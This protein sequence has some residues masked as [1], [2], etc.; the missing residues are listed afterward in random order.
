M[1]A[2]AP[3][4]GLVKTRLCPPLSDEQAA[5][6]SAAFALDTWRAVA[7]VSGVDPLLVYA[8][9][10]EAFPLALR[11]VVGFEQAGE[12]LGAR[13][14]NAARIGLDRA[15]RAIVIGSDAPALP[16]E[17]LRLASA[18]LQ[19]SDAVLGPALD[20]GYYLIGLRRCEPDLLAGLPWSETDTFTATR[21]RLVDRG[22]AVAVL[23]A[24]FDVDDRA[25]LSLLRLAL[26][27]GAI[28]APATAAAV[29]AMS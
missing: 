16:G 23:P 17:L 25:G 7:S 22:Y 27:A 2:K 24:W 28:D 13:I 19:D 5:A 1:M 8:G 11:G 10:R 20:G 26:R 29:E 6:L 3:V 9:D 12:D 4:P 15:A 21:D 18:R 14:E